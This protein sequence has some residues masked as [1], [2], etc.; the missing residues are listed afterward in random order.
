MALI[1]VILGGSGSALYQNVN[2]PRPDPFTGSM[3]KEMESRVAKRNQAIEDRIETIRSEMNAHF[4]RG[5][6]GFWRIQQLEK[7]CD[8]LQTELN[9]MRQRNDH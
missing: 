3:G 7:Q 5:E 9:T 2:P 1:A 4:V 8:K 6:A